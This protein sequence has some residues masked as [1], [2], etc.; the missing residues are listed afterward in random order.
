[1][2]YSITC[3][4]PKGELTSFTVTISFNVL[5]FSV[6]VKWIPFKFWTVALIKLAIWKRYLDCR[7]KQ[8]TFFTTVWYFIDLLLWRPSCFAMALVPGLCLAL[9]CYVCVCFSL[10]VQIGRD[11]ISATECTWPVHPECITDQPSPFLPLSL[12]RWL[13]PL[14][15]TFSFVRLCCT[16]L[17]FTTYNTTHSHMYSPTPLIYWLTISYIRFIYFTAIS[18]K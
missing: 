12:H 13:L 6:I 11:C 3:T 2:A 15:H 16:S 14:H 5:C 17:Q 10:Q 8:C 4:K 1:M 18:L 9:G 7:K